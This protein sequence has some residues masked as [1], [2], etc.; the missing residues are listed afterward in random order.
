MFQS[1][2]I[3][4]AVSAALLWLLCVGY[5]GAQQP[6][7][8]AI[9]TARELVEVKGASTT[10]DALVPGIVE[11]AKNTFLPTHPQLAK[12]LNDVA[13]QLRAEFAPRRAQMVS[14][15]ATIYAQHFT[16]AEMREAI[17]FYKSPTGRKFVSQEPVTVEQGLLRIRD[18]AD[19]TSSEVLSRFRAEMKK[20][21]HDL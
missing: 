19:K 11:T 17:A 13:A 2:T 9:A 8:S 6:S 16:E 18:I 21:G 5:A 10:F 20:K 14:D 15:F 1:M 12:E 7:P 4:P 3:R